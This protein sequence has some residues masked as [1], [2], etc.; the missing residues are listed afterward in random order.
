MIN[1][2]N[3]KKM[4]ILILI[5]L[6]IPIIGMGVLFIGMNFNTEIKVSDN[7]E[8]NITF[9]SNRTDK[10]VE[11]EA[12]IKE[13]EEINPKVNVTLELI[14]DAQS[15][16]QRK[17]SV[18]ELPDVTLVPSTISKNEYRNYF[19]ALDD[20]GF[21]DSN[22]YNY[23]MGTGNDYSLYCLNTS[24]TWQGI[25]YNK[26]IFK[27]ANI[28]R[29][30]TTIDELFQACNKIE[31]LGITPIAINYRQSWTMDLWTDIIPH[32]FDN[33]LSNDVMNENR[34]I[35]DSNGGLY[36]S[37]SLVREIV[38]RGY[39]EEDLFNYDWQQFK[40]DMSEGKI[41]MAIWNSDFIYQL[42]DM[43]MNI[44]SLGMF[45]IPETN[46]IKIYGDY[47]YAVSN[48]TDNPDTAK[49]FLKF[50]F[51]NNR[52]ANAVNIMSPLKEDKEVKEVLEKLGE[53]NI[54]II[55]YSDYISKQSMEVARLEDEFLQIKKECGIDAAFVQKF[56]IED[57]IDRL[58]NEINLKWNEQINK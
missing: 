12:L 43:G 33:N 36:K 34:Q 1:M 44:D 28:D 55:T 27:Q 45:P 53:L 25:I 47:M 15:I 37:L 8:G 42:E 46:T 23:F 32:L 26:D 39:A 16:L 13:F 20:L 22:I 19:L 24:I 10:S 51:E 21:N 57:D 9:V 4:I 3:N 58:I 2:G 11:I 54:P 48:T 14:G 49:A 18:G 29:L 52:Y 40:N 31:A 56:I 17:A 6:V 41:A 50:I 35:M 38:N 5:A 7:L 30:P